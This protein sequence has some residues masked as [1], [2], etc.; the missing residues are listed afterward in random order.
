MLCFVGI[1]LGREPEFD[2]TTICNFR[3]L[4]ERHNL[5]QWLFDT[6]HGDMDRR[7]IKVARRTIVD[8]TTISAPGS[9]NKAGAR[10][11][12][13]CPTRKDNQ[14]YF[15]IKAHIGGDNVTKV[16]HI[17]VATAADVAD[18]TILPDL[19][20]NNETWVWGDQA[21]GGQREAMR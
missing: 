1:D 20:H 18:C 10:D 11:P 4:L 21:Y 6:A 19:L 16:I 7:G 17:M 9:T 3:H 12:D 2:E 14:W 5:G 15:G 8:A 13:M